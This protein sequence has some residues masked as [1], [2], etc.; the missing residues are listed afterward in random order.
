MTSSFD[1]MA[2]PLSAIVAAAGAKDEK[3]IAFTTSINKLPELP[4]DILEMIYRKMLVSEIEQVFRSPFF[5]GKSEEDFYR[6]FNGR[7]YLAKNFIPNHRIS[8]CPKLEVYDAFCRLLESTALE[9]FSNVNKSAFLW[10]LQT[11]H[12]NGLWLLATTKTRLKLIKVLNSDNTAPIPKHFKWSWY[13]PKHINFETCIRHLIYM[14][15]NGIVNYILT[16]DKDYP[17]WGQGKESVLWVPEDRFTI[18]LNTNPY[19]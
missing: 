16:A 5:F 14:N 18:K 10:V 8:A 11:V 1:H 13:N 2:D 7:M 3:F 6:P 17:N 4:E 19:D 12:L 9:H 15:E